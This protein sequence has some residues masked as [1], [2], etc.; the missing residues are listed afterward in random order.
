MFQQFKEKFNFFLKDETGA[1]AIE[2]AVQ[3]FP[4]TIAMI[5][6][7]ET[8]W[9]M[10]VHNDMGRAA[11]ETGRYMRMGMTYSESG[12]VRTGWT[13]ADLQ[14]KFCNSLWIV[15]CKPSMPP[16]FEVRVLNTLA[17][18]KNQSI[19]DAVSNTTPVTM[20]NVIGHE[21][22]AFPYGKAANW[23]DTTDC[24]TEHSVVLFRV[25]MA[26]PALARLWNP[27]LANTSDGKT[28]ISVA[29][30]FTNEP[31]ETAY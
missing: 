7:F 28:V 11:A 26:F 10:M 25:Y 5:G 13:P 18:A 4:V 23:D 16:V 22:A 30:L 27:S 1:V 21:D 12:G 9:I 15:Q 24:M 31:Y 29:H 20:N 17:D 2:F 14:T 6:I 19:F 3:F 8:V